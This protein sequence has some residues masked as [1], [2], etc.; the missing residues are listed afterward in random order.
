MRPQPETPIGALS[1]RG[2][3][4][5]ITNE[6]STSSTAFCLRVCVR[7]PVLPV[8]MHSPAN[9]RTHTIRQ[10]N[11]YFSEILPRTGNFTVAWTATPTETASR[12]Q[13]CSVDKGFGLSFPGLRERSRGWSGLE[14]FV[15]IF[16]NFCW[17]SAD[18]I[19]RQWSEVEKTEMRF[20]SERGS[21]FKV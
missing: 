1:C 18:A 19:W 16:G 10:S 17:G 21:S 3:R 7:K 4:L 14:V 15:R 20:Y 9:L 12:R 13:H 6:R 2:Q 11:I 8:F 5:Y